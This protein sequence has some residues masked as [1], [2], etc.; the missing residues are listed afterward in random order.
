MAHALG[1]LLAIALMI[2]GQSL[3]A[4]TE[5]DSGNG[6]DDEHE[7]L[8]MAWVVTDQ[9]HPQDCLAA[10]VIN[11]VDGE[12]RVVSAKG[13]SIEPGVHTLNGLAILDT[14][15]CSITGDERQIN[16]APDLQVEFDAGQSYFIGYD[17]K[18]EGSDE[19]QLVVW[20]VEQ[21]APP[22]NFF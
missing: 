20:K 5:D 3:F 17:F 1:N 4:Q 9:S 15:Y 6:M 11:R 8:E 19:R 13:F 21:T 14:S 18:P 22:E 16:T 12:P 7:M 2:A 10:V